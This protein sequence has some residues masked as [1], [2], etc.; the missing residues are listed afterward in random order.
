M[1]GVSWYGITV[2]LFALGWAG[3]ASVL[4]R[5]AAVRTGRNPRIAAAAAAVIAC[6]V[7]S[8]AL[9][10]VP[11]SRT[12]DLAPLGDGPR[13]ACA[14]QFVSAQHVA[15]GFVDQIRVEP[16][17]IELADGMTVEQERVI[18][19]SGW[20]TDAL[21]RKP[22]AGVCAAIDGAPVPGEA[23]VYGVPRPDVARVFKQASIVPTGFEVRVPTSAIAAGPHVLTVVG[24]DSAGRDE[25]LAPARRIVVTPP[26]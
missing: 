17:D 20:A 21:T 4:A 19:L 22:I 13:V 26:S 11:R 23:A 24:I 6:A 7:T 12:V 25:A 10:R 14:Q 1:Y 8:V 15:H 5:A 3:L 2:M 9:A 18:T 16:E